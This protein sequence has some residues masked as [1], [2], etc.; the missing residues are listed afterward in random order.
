MEGLKIFK[1]EVLNNQFLEEGYVKIQLF[2]N[3]DCAEIKK[4]AKKLLVD[5]MYNRY[6]LSTFPNPNSTDEECLTINHFFEKLLNQ[7]ITKFVTDDFSCYQSS[8]IIKKRKSSSLLWHIDPS[9]YNTSEKTTPLNLWAGIDK[10]NNKNGGFRLVPKSHKLAFDYI[11]FPFNEFEAAFK[12]D[13][14]I[15][16]LVDKHA[17]NIPLKKGEVIIHNQALLHASHP[18]NSFFKKR[19]AYK[20]ILLPK[21]IDQLE[22][23][24]FTKKNNQINLLKVNK[25]SINLSPYFDYNN[26]QSLITNDNLTKSIPINNSGFPYYTL[27]EMEKIMNTSKVST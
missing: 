4:M 12:I 21:S 8:F 10:T 1:D 17:I 26:F 23:A 19:I 7:K 9:F 3:N 27:E 25:N 14:S 15:Q 24:Y 6:D 16:K 2:N 20:I 18:N 22:F 5:K 13:K 11:P